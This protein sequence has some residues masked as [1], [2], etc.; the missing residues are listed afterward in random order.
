[1]DPQKAIIIFLVMCLSVCCISSFL[2]IGG[3]DGSSTSPSAG[4]SADDE[5]SSADDDDPPDPAD[6]A[7]TQGGSS[8]PGRYVRLWQGHPYRADTAYSLNI[9]ELEVYD[10]DGKNI[11]SVAP[12]KATSSSVYVQPNADTE[13][14][15]FMAWKAFDDNTD[16]MYHSLGDNK[17]DWLE[18]DL[19]S[20][21]NI[22]KIVIKHPTDTT[23]DRGVAVKDRLRGYIQI[24]DGSGN[25]R[26]TPQFEETST[27]GTYTFDFTESTPAWKGAQGTL[28]IREV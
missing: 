5:E 19:G 12:I 22:H 6:P 2:S 1:M 15:N 10:G 25:N 28:K 24:K 26:T 4:P 20:V 18:I 14:P 9:I 23:V 8:I 7:D 11:A 17:E 16:T 21:Q 3:D 27:D 13:D